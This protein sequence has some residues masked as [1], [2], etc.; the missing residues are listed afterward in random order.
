[1]ANDIEYWVIMDKGKQAIACGTPRN[2]SMRMLHTL[3]KNAIRVLLYGSRKK[4]LA[5]FSGG[6]GFYDQTYKEGN[7]P[8]PTYIAQTYP[9]AKDYED[10]CI[11]VRVR[12]VI[13]E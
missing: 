3:D 7:E 1:M 10:I 9:D 8:H 13:D 5:G 2:R 6:L 4:A 12:L 11:P